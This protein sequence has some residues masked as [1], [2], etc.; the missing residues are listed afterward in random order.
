M[1]VSVVSVCVRSVRALDP[2]VWPRL[3]MLSEIESSCHWYYD[4]IYLISCGTTF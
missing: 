2:M 4:M 3:Y 1:S